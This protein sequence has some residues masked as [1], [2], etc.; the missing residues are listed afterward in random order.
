MIK[1]LIGL[2]ITLLALC[3]VQSTPKEI[4]NS[5]NVQ[6]VD[7]S[8]KESIDFSLN[9]AIEI[10][11]CSYIQTFKH[12]HQEYF[13]ILSHKE[14][15]L[16]VFDYGNRSLRSATKIT[17]LGSYNQIL[18]FTIDH[19]DTFYI[20]NLFNDLSELK[21]HVNGE[22]LGKRQFIQSPF[23]E[24]GVYPFSDLLHKIQKYQDNIYCN[25]TIARWEQSL[26]VEEQQVDFTVFP[27]AFHFSKKE[28][29]L[30]FLFPLSPI[31]NT[32]FWGGT[33]FKYYSHFIP[34]AGTDHFFVSYGIDPQVYEF[35]G[36][37]VVRSN[38]I[39]SKYLPIIRPMEQ[40]INIFYAMAKKL[41]FFSEE[42][43]VEYA[44]SNSE[45]QGFLYN[46][47]KDVYIRVAYLRPLEFDMDKIPRMSLIFFDKNLKKLGETVLPLEYTEYHRH[48]M[49]DKGLHIFKHKN[50][51]SITFDLFE[52]QENE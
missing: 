40:D 36:D 26:D 2:Q 34:K 9:Q 19:P 18:S 4:S 27:T 45:Y 13:A 22:V 21:Y 32:A 24:R 15:I 39:S 51:E 20:Y 28:A 17:G 31:Y 14:P 25:L 46:E 47:K 12:N 48:F 6:N 7:L 37:Q 35:S 23:L 49:N 41:E 3:C 50:S 5:N 44:F 1:V 30:S 52:I 11:S 8:F 38:R 16:L 29:D 33:E 10:H 42:E 43:M